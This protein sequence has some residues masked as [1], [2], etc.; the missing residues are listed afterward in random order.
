[1]H[2]IAWPL[3]PTPTD[4]GT[5]SDARPGVAVLPAAAGPRQ[6]LPQAP[7]EHWWALQFTPRVARVDG[8]ALLLEVSGTERLWG[9]RE[10]LLVQLQLRSPP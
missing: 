7:H 10:A 5:D 8:E 4:T 6:P 3:P 2:W 1:M 9:G